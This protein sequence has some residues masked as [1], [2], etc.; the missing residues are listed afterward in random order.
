MEWPIN[1]LLHFLGTAKS[2]QFNAH[3]NTLHNICKNYR[4]R[5]QVGPAVFLARGPS[6]VLKSCGSSWDLTL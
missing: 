3:Y 5:S 6:R 2:L 1:A 4:V